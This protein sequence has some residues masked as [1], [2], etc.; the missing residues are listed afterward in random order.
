MLYNFFKAMSYN[1]I[2]IFLYKIILQT[3][4]LLLFSIIPSQLFG[5]IGTLF[6]SIYFLISVT[7]IGFDYFIITHHN[8]YTAS[9]K[10]F[11][12][13]IPLFFAR[14]VCMIM[15]IILL[16]YINRHIL[17]CPVANIIEH[18]TPLLLAIIIFI[19]ISESIKKSLDVLAQM[20]F[21]Q[22]TISIFDISTLI[23]YV[24]SVWSCYCLFGQISLL[25]IFI[26]MAIISFAECCLLAQ[27][28]YKFYTRIPVEDSKSIIP[29]FKEIIGNQ[30][31]NYINQIAKALFSPNFFIIV[32]ACYL[33]LAKVGQ[34]KLFTDIIVLLYMV[35]N[36]SFGLPTAALF[37]SIAKQTTIDK[38][39]EK[40]S[41]SQQTFVRVITWYT[42]FL[43]A[44]GIT[45]GSIVI[46]CLC[47]NLCFSSA[48]IF[49][50]ILFIFAGFIEYLVIAYEKWYL[51]QRKSWILAIANGINLAMY[52]LLFLCMHFVIHIPAEFILIPIILFRLCF[53]ISIMYI[54]HRIWGI[55]ISW[56]IRML[57]IGIS[58]L[59]SLMIYIIN[60]YILV[61]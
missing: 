14:L 35:L 17:L 34:I 47:I 11:K 60:Y 48:V 7:N 33:G 61:L 9:Q 55:V 3:H 22:K 29:S 57:T 19:F 51:T 2:N 38:D 40:I 16:W 30:I 41:I 53:I 43:Y 28:I 1:V 59:V 49:N 8:I 24:S 20:L 56:R 44:L 27:T 52:G 50:I 21:L 6:S 39:Q 42:Q 37:S 5:L 12:K 26:P 54:A 36:R 15:V 46:S 23:I 4:Q 18:T 45:I 10:N 32:L 58:S 13:L 31:I 25:T